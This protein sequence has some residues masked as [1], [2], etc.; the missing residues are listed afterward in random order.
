MKSQ[1]ACLAH[2]SSIS[3]NDL[4]VW[5]QR[6]CTSSSQGW[7]SAGFDPSNILILSNC[8]SNLAFLFSSA[9]AST[10]P[11]YGLVQRVR[12]LRRGPL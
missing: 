12:K 8:L 4:P 10:S 11:L 5:L 1:T 3:L 7:H 9:W 2:K 6:A